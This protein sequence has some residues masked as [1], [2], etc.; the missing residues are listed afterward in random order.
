AARTVLGRLVKDL[1]GGAFPSAETI[2]AGGRDVLRGPASRVNTIVGA[3]EALA[4][5][6]LRLDVE[7]PAVELRERLLALPGIGPWTADYLA[8]RVLGNP[9][10]LLG[11]DL[12]VRQSA[13]A[14]G[15]PG[16]LRGLDQRGAPWSP[17]CSY[18][19]VHLWRA[20]PL[21]G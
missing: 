10:I 13:A 21:R 4:S 15:L 20:R 3:A 1:G 19:T 6:E 14:L 9:D 11:T 2:A 18:A 17:W 5:G 7:T 8:M 12:V 16:D